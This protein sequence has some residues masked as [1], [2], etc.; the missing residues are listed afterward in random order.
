[1]ARI[2]RLLQHARVEVE[3]GQLAVDEPLR[4]PPGGRSGRRRAPVGDRV[5][6]R[7][8][9]PPYS[10]VGAL[11]GS[12]A[13]ASAHRIVVGVAKPEQLGAGSARARARV[14][15]PPPPGRRGPAGPRPRRRP[16][17]RGAG[18]TAARPARRPPPAAGA[19]RSAAPAGR[20]SRASAG[21]AIADRDASREGGWRGRAG[22]P[23][24]GPAGRGR[25]AA[26][27]AGLGAEVQQVEQR[28]LLGHAVGIV[29]G[30]AG[31]GGM[32]AGR[33]A[34]AP[35]STGQPR[36][37]ASVPQQRRLADPA[38]PRS[39]SRPCGQDL[40]CGQPGAA[41]R[42]WTRRASGHRA[43]SAAAGGSGMRELAGQRE[44]GLRERQL[45]GLRS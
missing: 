15:A 10:R 5:P 13:S 30:E 20:R 1:M 23:A 19:R 45:G 29:H 2:G 17:P 31:A 38:G 4:V 27:R 9:P 39:A 8:M 18:A 12:R 36:R 21:G 35:S 25:R 32:R 33:A 40:G 24:S 14:T 28:G 34:P 42:R 7:L 22:R 3:P 41:P 37:A 43:R 16:R 44:L 26:P 6:V 11:R